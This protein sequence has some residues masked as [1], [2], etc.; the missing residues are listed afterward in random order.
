MPLQW[1]DNELSNFLLRNRACKSAI[2]WFAHS[3]ITKFEDA[4]SKC[5]EPGWLLWALDRAGFSGEAESVGRR[6]VYECLKCVDKML[7]DPRSKRA[8]KVLFDSLSSSVDE[9]RLETARRLAQ[10]AVDAC[11]VSDASGT[12]KAVSPQTRAAQALAASLVPVREEW[13]EDLDY[14]ASLA[15]EADSQ[16]KTK[17]EVNKPPWQ[18]CRQKQAEMIRNMITEAELKELIDSLRKV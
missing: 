13:P 11:C 3:K 8:M 17:L 16:S 10:Q 6:Y 2:D 18:N 4:W 5:K 12:S 1:G 7:T 9:G 15:A 14:A